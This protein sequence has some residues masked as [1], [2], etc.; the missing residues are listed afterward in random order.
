MGIRTRHGGILRPIRERL[1]YRLL[2]A[3]IAG[4]LGA[5]FLLP[6]SWLPV[7]ETR[8]FFVPGAIFGVVVMVTMLDDPVRHPLRAATL[9]WAATI[10]HA[11]LWV[12]GFTVY[13]VLEVL[14]NLEVLDA[15]LPQMSLPQ[16]IGSVI[17]GGPPGVV[18][19]LIVSIAMSRI[20]NL[21]FGRSIWFLIVIISGASGSIYVSTLLDDWSNLEGLMFNEAPIFFAYIIWY[22]AT[23]AVFNLGKTQPVT[24]MTKLDFILFG[25]LVLLTTYVGLEL[26]WA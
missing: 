23:S 12:T 2:L 25:V 26:L 11:A 10:A 6:F 4:W 19:G 24:S 22:V 3:S 14:E 8:G 13:G 15:Y 16:W 7:P 21:Q 1:L 5:W 18:F 17:W 20:L 9:V